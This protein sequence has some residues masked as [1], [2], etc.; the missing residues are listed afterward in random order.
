MFENL[1]INIIL[2]FALMLVGLMFIEGI[3]HGKGKT[4]KSYID[5]DNL[6]FP[7]LEDKR[8]LKSGDQLAFLICLIM[9]LCTLFNGL[10]FLFFSDIPN[11]SAVFVFIVVLTWPIRIIFIYVN[12]NKKYEELSRI[13]PFSKE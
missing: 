8:I 9:S 4:I 3:W 7:K 2:S 6:F 12:K 5:I 13:W 11:V 1:I 10:L